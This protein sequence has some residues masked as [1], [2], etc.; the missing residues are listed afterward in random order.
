MKTIMAIFIVALVALEGCSNP[1]GPQAHKQND[2]N[3]WIV[4]GH[5]TIQTGGH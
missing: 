1:M 5:P 2:T 4:A 3:P